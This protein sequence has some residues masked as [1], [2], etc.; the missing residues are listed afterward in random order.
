MLR[1]RSIEI[2]LKQRRQRRAMFLFALALLILLG[3]CAVVGVRLL[4]LPPDLIAVGT[5]DDYADGRLHR[6][7]VPRLTVSS[8]ITRRDETLS[9]DAVYVRHTPGGTWVALLGIDAL[10]G[11]FLYWDAPAELFRDVNCQGANYTLDGYYRDGLKSGEPPQNMVRLPV[12]V[13]DGAVFVR[14]ERARE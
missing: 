7:S 13:R 3:F 6:L 14:D 2:A 4:A 8:L 10:S 12:V 1:E 5:V 9:E 11:C